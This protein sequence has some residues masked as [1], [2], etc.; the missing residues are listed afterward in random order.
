[1]IRQTDDGTSRARRRVLTLVAAA[2]ICIA[3]VVTAH[4][5]F[6]RGGF[7][8]A[9]IA[10]PRDFDGRFH[11]CRIFYSA[12]FDG[13]GGSWTTDYPRADI[14]IS[15]RLSELTKTRVSSDASGQ[16]NTLIV[17][18]SGDELFHCPL[19]IMSAPGRA[20]ISETEAPRLQEYLLK[21]G[22]LWADDFWGTYQW[23]H[24]V[25]QLRKVLPAAQYEIFDV[26]LDH[27]MFRA[28]FEVPEIPQIPNIG[29][30]IRS[31]GGTSEQ[32][33]DSA[34]PHARAIADR[35]GRIMVLMTHNTDIADSWEREGDD[36]SYFYAFG[37]RGYA[38]GINV[39]LYAMT[40]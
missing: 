36:P 24:W 15:I 22:M 18:M 31:G 35:T 8:G 37:P 19:V 2:A 13:E 25:E 34:V 30:F 5:Q 27:P 10:T 21:G 40:H 6:G 3:A 33:A 20:L 38:F 32:G 1:V 16:P 9:R 12:A 7:A 28:Q 14:N 39:I 23:E 17:R 29:F 4:A 11:Y 26:P